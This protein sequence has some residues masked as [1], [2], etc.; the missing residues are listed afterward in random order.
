MDGPTPVSALI[1]AATM[2]AAG[3]YV[4]LRL[5]P[6]FVAAPS[7]SPS[8]G[9]RV[10]M[11][12]RRARRARPGRPEAGARLVHGQP[13]GVH[14]GGADRRAGSR[15]APFHLF[16]RR[17]QGA[18]FL[19]R[20]RCCIAAGAMLLSR[21][22]GLRRSMPVLHGL[23]LRRARAGRG[24]AAGRR[25]VQGARRR[26]ALGGRGRGAGPG[27]AVLLPR[28][29][30]CADRRVL[31]RAVLRLHRAP[32]SDAAHEPGRPDALAAGAARRG[33]S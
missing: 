27:V 25:A 11:P 7:R 29:A 16:A 13:A 24:A 28:S 5:F 31:T 1:H 17:V 18:L 15:P 21:L 8:G 22:G 30:P 20:A 32:R 19:C 14:A 23:P 9:G 33:P 6:A 4:V 2:V 26:G 3:V 12:L 10:T